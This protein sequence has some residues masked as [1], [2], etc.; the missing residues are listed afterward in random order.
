[1]PQNHKKKIARLSKSCVAH[2][3]LLLFR[4]PAV[5]GQGPE[6]KISAKRA[7]VGEIGASEANSCPE[8]LIWFASRAIRI[9][10]PHQPKPL[11][12]YVAVLHFPG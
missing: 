11:A 12:G 4:M 9:Q 10:T 2:A 1:M 6:G 5:L 7:V 8:Y 3:S